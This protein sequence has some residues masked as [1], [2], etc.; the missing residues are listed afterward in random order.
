MATI[1]TKYRYSTKLEQMV[2]QTS[3][4]TSHKSFSH[5]GDLCVWKALKNNSGIS[6]NLHLP[7]TKVGIQVSH[8]FR[9]NMKEHATKKKGR[10]PPGQ[11]W[12]NQLSFH[13]ARGQIKNPTCQQCQSEFPQQ[14]IYWRPFLF[15]FQCAFKL[16]SFS[17]HREVCHILREKHQIIIGLVES[18]VKIHKCDIST[19]DCFSTAVLAQTW[20]KQHEPLQY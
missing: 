14:Q 3:P 7:S 18:L 11:K 19:E 4:P 5:C 8:T 15:F 20:K 9:M 2:L 1:T 10:L 17:L 12:I 16:E 13:I 6:Q